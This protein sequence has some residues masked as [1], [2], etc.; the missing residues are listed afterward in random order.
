MVSDGEG[1]FNFF[2]LF[3]REKYP[4]G[5]GL[6]E[7][8]DEHCWYCVNLAGT[9]LKGELELRDESVGLFT[10]RGGYFYRFGGVP[11]YSRGWGLFGKVSAQS[12]LDSG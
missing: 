6:L 7:M 5:K 11:F 10:F 12:V 3:W 1:V 9:N 8:G 4:Q 2:D